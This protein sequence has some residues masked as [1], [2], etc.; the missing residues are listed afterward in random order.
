MFLRELQ[1]ADVDGMLEWMHDDEIQQFFQTSMVTITRE[2]ALEFIRTAQIHPQEGKSI[3]LAIINESGEYLG[4][5][6]LK[7]VDLVSKNAE[8]AI[9]LRKR[10][11]GKGVACEAIRE[12]LS[13]AFEEF[14]LERIYLNVLA[15]NVHAIRVYEKMGFVY[16]GEPRKSHYIRGEF[17]SLKWYSI[18]KDEYYAMYK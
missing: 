5:I 2:Q 11:Q 16:E 9:C 13:R 15:E 1:E 6:S 10:A 18:L 7:N 3:H 12:L 17:R 8:F 14:G 4:T